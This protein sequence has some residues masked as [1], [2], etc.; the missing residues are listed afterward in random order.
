MT[1]LRLGIIGLSPGNGHPYS[2]SAIFNGYDAAEMA[3]CPFPAIPEYLSR[4]IFPRDAISNAAVTHIWTQ[5]R[6]LSSSIARASRIR[7]VVEQASDMV[8]HVDALLLARDDAENHEAI[9]SPFL[10]A[11]LPVYIDKPL[12]LDV[13]TAHR[14]YARCQR[15]G[16]IFTGTA[17]SFAPE[18]ELD[19]EQRKRLGRIR[20]VDAVAPKSWDLYAI[21]VIEPLIAIMA[22]EGSVC[23]AR[24]IDD[25][26]RHLDVEWT[27]G[28]TAR[29]TALGSRQGALEIVVHGE[30][31]SVA[32]RLVDTFRAF[33]SALQAFVSVVRGQTPPQDQARI[34]ASIAL[35]EAGRIDSRLM[36]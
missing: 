32:M 25:E 30:N 17:L 35:L 34:L 24:S 13:A 14:L 4:Q 21:H 20:H 23:A 29:I 8:G 6:A 31:G 33:K 16:Q 36:P 18:F 5:D 11:G 27:S 1:D 15:P 2:W 9:A 19:A 26:G 22:C 28:A 7:T 12:A 3:R 10:D